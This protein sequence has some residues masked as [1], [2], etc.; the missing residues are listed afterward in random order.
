[1]WSWL[2]SKNTVNDPSR[3]PPLGAGSAH[4]LSK[5]ANSVSARLLEPE[6]TVFRLTKEIYCFVYGNSPWT[7]VAKT[8]SLKLVGKP[9]LRSHITIQKIRQ[10][11]GGEGYRWSLKLS[12]RECGCLHLILNFLAEEDPLQWK[13]AVHLSSLSDKYASELHPKTRN[14]LYYI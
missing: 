10:V 9:C 7:E 5:H 6:R 1:M 12:W 8:F 2:S 14:S 3:E 11:L 4:G 13:E